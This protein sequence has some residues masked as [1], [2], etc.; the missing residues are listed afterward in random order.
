M[1]LLNA[2]LKAGVSPGV[3]WLCTLS[4]TWCNQALSQ[5]HKIHTCT[6]VAHRN[7]HTNPHFHDK[8]TCKIKCSDCDFLL[9][10]PVP[11]STKCLSKFDLTSTASF[12]IKFPIHFKLLPKMEAEKSSA[13]CFSNVQDLMRCYGIWQTRCMVIWILLQ[14][15]SALDWM[16]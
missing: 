2:V 15:I 3:F 8:A 4:W 9:L 11:H 13:P 1:L 10:K 7:Q 14:V 16:L 5:W 12:Y 6:R